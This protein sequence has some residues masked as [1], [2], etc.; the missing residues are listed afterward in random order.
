MK[1]LPTDVKFVSG[2][3]QC[4]DVVAQEERFLEMLKAPPLERVKT[5]VQHNVKK[6]NAQYFAVEGDR[7]VGWC[8]I[9]PSDEE[10]VAH[11]GILGM[12]L[13]PGFRRKGYGSQ[14]IRACLEHAKRKGIE[15]VELTVYASNHAA[16]LF[17]E[18]HG[19]APEGLKKRYRKVFGNYDD[20]LIMAK[21]L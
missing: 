17:Y 10:T 2:F 21:F 9:V 15:R 7:V 6:G 19:F 20:A 16:I 13:I 18:K 5:F 14:M 1:I 8:D 4:L 3:H 11:V 12:G